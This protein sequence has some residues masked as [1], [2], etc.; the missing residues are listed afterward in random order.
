RATSAGV[1]QTEANNF[2]EKRMK[3]KSDLTYDE[4]IELA[5]ST[6]ANVLSTDLKPSEI[7]ISVVTK[8][9]DKVRILPE[10]E[11]E[12]HLTRIAEKE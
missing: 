11:I 10:S 1:K 9:N 6:L 4:S 7:E 2:L 12:Q 5:I 3:K 8:D